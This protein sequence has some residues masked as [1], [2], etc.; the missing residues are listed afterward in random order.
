M[1][2]SSSISEIESGPRESLAARYQSLIRV[3]E[4]IRAHRDPQELFHLLATELSH[5][6][7]FDAIAQFDEAAN[8]IHW[9]LCRGCEQTG[10]PSPADA[11]R[12]GTIP[13]WVYRHQK[14]VVI[15]FVDRETRF[16]LSVAQLRKYGMQSVCALPISTAHRH[17]GSLVL[18]SGQ[19][20][21]YADDEVRFLALVVAQIALA[22]DDALNF[23]ASKRAQERLELLLELT[24]QV[25]SNLELRDLLRAISV[26]IRRVMQ[27]DGV[28]VALPDPESNRLRIYALDFPGGK[29]TIQ[30]GILTP[31]EQ[32]SGAARAMR[33]GERINLT[34]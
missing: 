12:E 23:Q 8:K 2:G 11:E 27:C 26:S 22:M 24:N 31:A 4:A 25:V 7:Q 13:W 17:L 20:D 9:H 33:S 32:A 15:P 18:A 5:V 29:G 3:A 21:A 34:G 16:P 19:P 28:G 1:Q 6:V 30:E 10:A 14:P